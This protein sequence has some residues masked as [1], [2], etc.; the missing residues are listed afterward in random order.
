MRVRKKATAGMQRVQCGLCLW[1]SCVSGIYG[2]TWWDPFLEPPAPL[3]A[4]AL[5]IQVTW[6]HLSSTLPSLPT[7][8]WYCHPCM[9]HPPRLFWTLLEFHCVSISSKGQ[10]S[11]LEEGKKQKNKNRWVFFL[12]TSLTWHSS[13]TRHDCN[14]S[15]LHFFLS[16][17]LC[18]CWAN[19]T[20]AWATAISLLN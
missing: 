15:L 7:H 5:C 9:P 13:P 12:L 8:R 1:Q 10:I 3:R 11:T 17:S 18:Y 16:Y 2:F 4:D 14:H 20:T 19:L 6:C